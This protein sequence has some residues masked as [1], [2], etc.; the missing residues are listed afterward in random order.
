MPAAL[1]RAGGLP[2][3]P[4]HALLAVLEQVADVVAVH[5]AT[6]EPRYM[7]PGVSRLMRRPY[8]EIVSA[9]PL[10]YVHVDDLPALVSTFMSWVSRPGVGDLVEYRVALPNGGWCHVESIGNN[11]LHHPDIRGIVVSTRDVTERKIV[12]QTL[13]HQAL[14]DHLTGLANRSLFFERAD[15]ALARARR[16]GGKVA[17]LFID[18]DAFKTINDTL[19]HS[20]GDDVL[21]E[22]GERLLRVVGPTDTVARLGGDEFVVLCEDVAGDRE[23]DELAHRLRQAIAEPME[24][25]GHLLR[26]SASVGAAWSSGDHGAE[27]LLAQ[28]D[29]SM[30]RAKHGIVEHRRSDD[31]ARE[32]AIIGAGLAV[33]D[34]A[35][36][37]AIITDMQLR[38]LHWSDGAADLYGRPPAEA[39]GRPLGEL[40]HWVVTTEEQARARRILFEH[41]RWVGRTR[42]LADRGGGELRTIDIDSTATLLRGSDGS[43]IGIVSVHRPAAPDSVLGELE[44]RLTQ[45]LDRGEVTVHYQPIVDAVTGSLHK[46]EALARWEHPTFGLLPP[47]DFIDGAER[48][49]LISRL[50]LAVIAEATVQV[51]EWREIAPQLE[52]AINVSPRQ[53]AD[54]QLVGA[55][56]AAL[57]SSGLPASALWVEVTETAV[58]EDLVTAS[59]TISALRELG[60]RVAIDDFGVGSSTLER[61]HHHRVDAIKIDRLFVHDMGAGGDAAIV[62]SVIALGHDLGAKVIAEGVETED[63]REALASW[64]CD[65]LQGFLFG[66]PVSAE[67]TPAWVAPL[68]PPQ[69]P[70]VDHLELRRLAALEACGVL[71]TPP[72]EVYDRAV[73]IAREVFAAPI[74]LVGMV[75]AD[76]QWFK[77]ADGL[78]VTETPRSGAFCD[79]PVRTRSTLVVA[80][81]TLDERFA[82][83]PIVVGHPGVRAYAGA[84]IVLR[85]G[86]ALGTIC[87]LDTEPRRFSHHQLASLERLAHG[88]SRML[89]L[90]RDA[91]RLQTP[92]GS[93]T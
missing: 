27:T 7:S 68:P 51:V 43:P 62:R 18:V 49:G 37:A 83:N 34:A 72:E 61:L 25:A 78:D 82:D 8:D 47:G 74:A 38:I 71:D 60:V 33:A 28:A 21:V 48:S 39:I 79:V 29:A 76:R 15:G 64:G 2:G 50:G 65:E 73:A 4:D 66:S 53:L 86:C 16:R 41:G 3:L 54:D 90:Q 58:M 40:V 11:Q 32:A 6:G 81:A 26:P 22:L 42:H 85:D 91:R 92:T 23:V 17:I 70:V 36:G 24:V 80:D 87:V 20:G 59:N 5:E 75:A 19:G 57:E 46:V 93:A 89:D 77:A 1:P 31:H 69:A 35:E 67:P 14:H 63:Q 10:R 56:Q 55:V 13:Q 52:L 45:A 44:A 12:E 30:Y 84:P 9:E 88:L